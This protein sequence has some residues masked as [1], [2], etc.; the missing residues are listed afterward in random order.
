MARGSRCLTLEFGFLAHIVRLLE[1][2]RKY[3]RGS[4]CP[5]LRDLRVHLRRYK[6]VEGK[7]R[8]CRQFRGFGKEGAHAI[9]CERAEEV[10]GCNPYQSSHTFLRAFNFLNI[11]FLTFR[12]PSTPIFRV[13]RSSISKGY[14]IFSLYAPLIFPKLLKTEVSQ[15]WQQLRGM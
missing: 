1:T 8:R 15:I 14:P 4:G 9:G 7:R 5:R 6:W 13:F 11:L 10:Y 2:E 3:L 12:V